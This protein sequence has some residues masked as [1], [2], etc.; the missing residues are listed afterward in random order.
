MLTLLTSSRVRVGF[1]DRL[2][3]DLPNFST[4]K[5]LEALIHQIFPLQNFPT[6]GI[7]VLSTANHFKCLEYMATSL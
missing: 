7:T 1:L 5:A 4:P 2:R 6:Y 3:A